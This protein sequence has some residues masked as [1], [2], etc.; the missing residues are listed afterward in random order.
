LKPNNFPI[1]E[2]MAHLPLDHRG[3][4]IFYIA[5]RTPD[6]KVLFTANDDRKQR[7][8]AALDLCE[9]CGQKLL[10]KRWFIGGP[11]SA[12]HPHGSYIDAP[13]HDE[14]AHYSLNVCPWLSAPNY[15]KAIGQLQADRIPELVTIDHTTNPGRPALFVAVEC[16]GASL[17][18]GDGGAIHFKPHRPY[19][20]IEF[21]H[22]GKQLPEGEALQHLRLEHQYD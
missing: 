3:Y 5:M 14:C 2:R 10:K 21:W 15:G 12:L 17:F 6:G 18:M 4:P 8:V 20:S 13:M 16:T 9:V 19:C 22:H 11:L 1:P 7:E